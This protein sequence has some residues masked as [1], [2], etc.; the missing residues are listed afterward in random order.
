MLPSGALFS[1]CQ[2]F[3]IAGPGWQTA[4]A[5][6]TGLLGLLLIYCMARLYRLRT[7]PGWD[8]PATLVS[9]LATAFL[10]GGLFTGVAVSLLDNAPQKF[11]LPDAGLRALFFRQSINYLVFSGLVS[12]TVQLVVNV[13]RYP[14]VL[15]LE[16]NVAYEEPRRQPARRRLHILRLSLLVLAGLTILFLLYPAIA[17]PGKVFVASLAFVFAVASEITGRLLFYETG[18]RVGV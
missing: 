18:L 12:L 1:G 10:L 7:T 6:L 4:L 9:F 3:L 8:T 5:W 15:A 16:K 2:W 14:L 17:A 11:F 13:V